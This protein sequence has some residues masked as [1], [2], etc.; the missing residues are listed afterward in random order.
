MGDQKTILGLGGEAQRDNDP[1]R[2]D[3]VRR[4]Q[5][6]PQIV[7]HVSALEIRAYGLVGVAL[8][9]A[10]FVVLG[11][12]KLVGCWDVTAY[13]PQIGCTVATGLF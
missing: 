5:Y 10:L 1:H 6:D 12:V 7:T 3:Y 11:L 4:D 13:N 2:L 8:G 9:V